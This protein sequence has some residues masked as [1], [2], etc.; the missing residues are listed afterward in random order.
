[1]PRRR[2]HAPEAQAVTFV[3]LFFDLVFVFAVTQVTALTAR[4]LN[5]SGVARSVLLFWLIW[6]AWTQFT[7]TL[8]PADTEHTVVRAVTL[9]ATAVA[10]MM[11]ASVTLAF[12]DDVLWFAVP[13]VLVRL[14]GLGLQVRVDAEAATDDEGIYWWIGL[15]MIGLALVLVGSFVDTPARSWIWLLAVAGDLIAAASGGNRHQWELDS[16][17]FAERHGLFVIIALGESL[18]G[19]AL[20]VSSDPRT[21]ELVT[22]VVAALAVACLLWWTYFGWLKGALERGLAGTPVDR[23]G[24]VGRDAFSLGHFPL[25]CGIIGFAV[26]VEEILRHPA[27]VPSAEVTAALGVGTVLFVGFSAFAVWR[28]CGDVLAPRLAILA[29]T[30]GVLVLVSSWQPAW[31]FTAV[32]IGLFAIVL[33]EGNGPARVE[34]SSEAS[35]PSRP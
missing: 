15:S 23:L 33:V 35:G 17:H 29:L 13:Y 31:Q 19:A 27:A 32:A 7:W 26:A 25:V 1:M 24:R 30:V 4:H 2:L 9:V 34:V 22:D 20:A 21:A 12:G 6:W 11:A 14:L 18:I 3:E 8:N 10:F 16:A 28:A 5:W